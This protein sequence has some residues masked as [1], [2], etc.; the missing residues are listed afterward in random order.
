MRGRRHPGIWCAMAGGDDHRAQGLH[1]ER[2]TKRCHKEKLQWSASIGED[3]S[4][5]VE[6]E[7]TTHGARPG[8]HRGTPA[9]RSHFLPPASIGQLLTVLPYYPGLDDYWYRLLHGRGLQC[10]CWFGRPLDERRGLSSHP[11]LIRFVQHLL[12][13]RVVSRLSSATDS[14]K[15]TKALEAKKNSTP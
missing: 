6:R 8:C 7:D 14:D 3:Q 15:L 11:A 10:N 12:C 1:L 9:I 5:T 13:L 2:R 4:S